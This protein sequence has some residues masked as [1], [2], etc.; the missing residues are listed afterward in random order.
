MLKKGSHWEKIH[1]LV[2]TTRC[3]SDKMLVVHNTTLPA[4]D[5]HRENSSWILFY[6]Y[7]CTIMYALIVL[8]SW[9]MMRHK[10]PLWIIVFCIIF[11]PFFPFLLLYTVL[12]VALIGPT[13][14][15]DDVVA[16]EETRRVADER[17]VRRQVLVVGSG[18]RGRTSIH[19]QV[20]H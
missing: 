17:D 5:D 14:Q 6:F 18:T 1:S 20:I 11:F 10:Y 15:G 19:P 2:L 4:H 7:I 8:S 12:F 3:E 16:V 13:I 9:S